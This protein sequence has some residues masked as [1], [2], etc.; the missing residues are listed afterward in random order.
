MMRICWLLGLGWVALFELQAQRMSAT[1]WDHQELLAVELEIQ[2][3]AEH[4]SVAGTQHLQLRLQRAGRQV[5]FLLNERLRLVH[6]KDRGETLSVQRHGDTVLVDLGHKLKAGASANLE[7]LYGGQLEGSAEVWAGENVSLDASLLPPSAWWPC[8]PA[9]VDSLKLHVIYPQEAAVMTS[10]ILLAQAEQ[11]GCFLRRT[12]V[13]PYPTRPEQVRLYAGDLQ[14]NT[15]TYQAQGVRHTLHYL[16]SAHDQAESKASM[17]QL[18]DAL[19]GLEAQFGPYPFWDRPFYWVSAPASAE[20]A[21][22]LDGAMIRR[23]AGHWFGRYVR[24][25]DE[26]ARMMLRSLA[27][28]AEIVYVEK[29]FDR[30]TARRYLFDQPE[31]P[32]GPCLWEALR[33]QMGNDER[34]W[35]ML[36]ALPETFGYQAVDGPT[37]LDYLAAQLGSNPRLIVEQYLLYQQRPRLQYRW[38]ENRRQ[39]SLFVRWQTEVSALPLEVRFK[40][41]QETQVLAP[42]DTWQ[43]LEYKRISADKI[44]P[45]AGQ[46]Y[47][48]WE[49]TKP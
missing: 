30:Q 27:A 14:E 35:A 19:A 47:L 22:N 15:I 6:V 24:P 38:L 2:L 23:L 40:V 1:V 18:T 10:G 42:T 39:T 26:L 36:R 28:Y 34:W 7:I 43:K 48:L 8:V 44:A 20:Q 13:H 12:F 21:L 11:P 5:V 16:A 32:I 31:V 29:R 46:Q 45:A 3:D 37:L 25:S 49:Y 17:S 4:R 9:P 33:D 41:G